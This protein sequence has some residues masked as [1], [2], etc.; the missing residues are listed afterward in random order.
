MAFVGD[1]QATGSF[2]VGDT[3]VVVEQPSSVE[4][5][6]AAAS[7]DNTVAGLVAAYTVDFAVASS[8]AAS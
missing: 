5:W 8:V 7:Q 2:A 1:K 4:A 3:V 6:A